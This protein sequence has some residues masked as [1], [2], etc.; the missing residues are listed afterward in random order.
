MDE[1][2]RDLFKVASARRTAQRSSLGISSLTA[3]FPHAEV[4]PNDCARLAEKR[5]RL[6]QGN[7]KEKCDESE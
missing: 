2:G 1:Q 6:G 3:R 4:S 7:L 5:R